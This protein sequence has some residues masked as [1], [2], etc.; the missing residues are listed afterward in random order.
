M[1]ERVPRPVRWVL[2]GLAGLVLFTSVALAEPLGRPAYAT[3]DCDVVCD[4]TT[5][6]TVALNAC[7]AEHKHVI[8]PPDATCVVQSNHSPLKYLAV[9][10]PS[11]ATLEGSGPSSVIHVLPTVV[12]GDVRTA[13]GVGSNVDV[14]HVTVRNLAIRNTAPRFANEQGHAVYFT[15]GAEDLRI[16]DITVLGAPGDGVYLGTDVHTA[17]VRDIVVYDAYRNAVTVEG[18]SATPRPGI[19]IS[20]VTR[21]FTADFDPTQRGGRLVDFEVSGAGTLGAV[22]VGNTGP[23][24]IEM[25]NASRPVIVA[26]V[27][28]RIHTVTATKAV[29]VANTLLA[30]TTSATFAMQRAASGVVSANWM[31]RQQPGTALSVETY[32][33]FGLLPQDLVFDENRLLYGGLNVPGVLTLVDNVIT[34]GDPPAPPAPPPAP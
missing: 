23:G 22:V 9:H 1:F 32:T 20:G 7:L 29:I 16:H 14:Q 33:N 15:G 27:A 25:G 31:E 28:D 19:R 12:A 18:A 30:P 8:L 4:G 17:S 3:L 11:G 34:T 2:A 26:N 21:L 13:R 24:G 6:T 10:L 5:V